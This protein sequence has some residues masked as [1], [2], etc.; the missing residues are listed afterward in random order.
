MLLGVAVFMTA[1]ATYSIA[2]GLRVLA[3]IGLGGAVLIA[4]TSGYCYRQ[5]VLDRGKLPWFRALWLEEDA[6]D[7]PGGQGSVTPPEYHEL[8][9]SPCPQGGGARESQ[10][11]G[12]GTTAEGEGLRPV[13]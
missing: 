7:G 1:M 11:K 8:G 9:G 3:L 2:I 4:F 13:P 5:A 10:G 12:V 6:D